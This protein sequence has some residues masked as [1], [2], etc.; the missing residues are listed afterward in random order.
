MTMATPFCTRYVADCNKILCSTTTANCYYLSH[1]CQCYDVNSQPSNI[2]AASLNFG[3]KQWRLML[4]LSLPHSRLLGFK[5]LRSRCRTLW[6]RRCSTA[7]KGLR[8]NS[9]ARSDVRILATA[10][11][12]PRRSSDEHAIFSGDRFSFLCASGRMYRPV[13][14]ASCWDACDQ[15]S[16]EWLIKTNELVSNLLCGFRKIVVKTYDLRKYWFTNSA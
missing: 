1:N 6:I 10:P 12:S 8:C 7:L 5:S 3:D 15:L 13:N 16:A 14:V 4:C 11:G 9:E 2:K